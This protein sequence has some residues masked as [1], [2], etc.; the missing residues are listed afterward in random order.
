MKSLQIGGFANCE[1]ADTGSAAKSARSSYRSRAVL[2]V[3]GRY[4]AKRDR[5]IET[6]A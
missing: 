3:E 2:A 1:H 4:E 6:L 5:A